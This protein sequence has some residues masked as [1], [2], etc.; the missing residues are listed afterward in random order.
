MALGEKTAKDFLKPHFQ[1]VSMDLFFR[2][3]NVPIS[4]AQMGVLRSIGA[5]CTVF[6]CGKFQLIQG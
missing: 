6:L 4:S 2:C 5:T 3:E 1:V